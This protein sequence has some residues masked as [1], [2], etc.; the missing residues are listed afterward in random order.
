MKRLR[1]MVLVAVV[2]LAIASLSFNAPRTFELVD[3][4]GAAL[5]PI[6]MAYSYIGSRPNFVHSVTYQAKP[7]ALA[8]SD[9]AG[10]VTIPMAF[11]AHLPFHMQTNPRLLI[12]LLY[13]PLSHNALSH[14]DEGAPSRKDV[15]EIDVAGR[16][17]KIFNLAEDPQLWA[18]TLQN[19]SSLIHR[20]VSPPPGEPPL[21]E[22]DPET[23]SLTRELIGHFRQEY[24]AFLARY[25]DV[26]RPFPEMP[27]YARGST[28]D[29]QRQWKASIEAS[30]AREPLWGQLIPRL[31]EDDLQSFS[32]WEASSR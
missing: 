26:E 19:L 16:R 12:E 14:L 27:E 13:V 7:L 9:G 2:L 11:H 6:Y 15:F 1:W 31:F 30:L 22:A 24:E 21:R 17:A 25:R 23:A 18:D 4:T 28:A 5:D 10:R 3:T 29:E 32:K 20:L 8:R